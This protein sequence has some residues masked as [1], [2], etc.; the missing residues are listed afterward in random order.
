MNM[1]ATIMTALAVGFVSGGVGV[2]VGLAVMKE[3]IRHLKQDL[4]K[5]VK[6]FDEHKIEVKEYFSRVVFR[7]VCQGCKGN[8]NERHDEVIRRLTLLEKAQGEAITA[9]RECMDDLVK[10]MRR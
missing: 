6:D 10:E 1:L 3:Q 7:D 8:G 5:T 2:L 4:D 9:F